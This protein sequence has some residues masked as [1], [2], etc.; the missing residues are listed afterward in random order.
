MPIL[1]TFHGNPTRGP[2]EPL[3]K[4]SALFGSRLSPR[5]PA[6][7]TVAPR[8]GRRRRSPIEHPIEFIPNGVKPSRPSPTTGWRAHGLV[9]GGYSCSPRPHGSHPRACPPDG[10]VDRSVTRSAAPG[11]RR[12]SRATTGPTR[13]L[14]ARCRP[15]PPG[16]DPGLPQP[17]RSAGRG[18][19]VHLSVRIEALSMMR[20]EVISC[21]RP[22]SPRHRRRTPMSPARTTLAVPQRRCPGPGGKLARFLRDGPVRNRRPARTLR[23]RL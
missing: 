8:Q 14:L 15:R 20:L 16:A 4:A 10:P 21:A 22:C 13:T 18:A 1:G 12:A 9:P 11:R 23:P 5:L 3:R 2:V 7:H 17:E 6:A 19:S